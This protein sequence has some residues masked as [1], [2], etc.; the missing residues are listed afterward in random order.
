MIE[1]NYLENNGVISKLEIS[2]HA[3][4]DKKGKDI[5]CSAISAIGVGGINALTNIDE[6]EIV[7]NDGYILVNGSGLNNEYN[8]IVLKTML[9][10]LKTIE[11]SY[12]KYI[13][14]SKW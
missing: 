4:F 10:Q 8:Q 1:V 13:K 12:S 5:V 6:I 11:K 3:N 7:I 14:V 2:G 9:T